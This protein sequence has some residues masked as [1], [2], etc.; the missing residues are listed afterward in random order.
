MN[1]SDVLIFNSSFITVSYQPKFVT[2]FASDNVRVTHG[3]DFVLNCDTEENPTGKV[4]WVFTSQKTNI[5]QS[6]LHDEK[7]FTIHGMNELKQ[8]IYECEVKNS[9]GAVKRKFNV[10]DYPKGEKNFPLMK[11]L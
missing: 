6:I 5:K 11:I 4:S 2:D 10:V 3:S 7:L 9:I 1:Y 8:G